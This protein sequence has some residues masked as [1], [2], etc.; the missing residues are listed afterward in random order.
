MVDI[1]G[2]KTPVV[3]GSAQ[4]FTDELPETKKSLIVDA[5]FNKNPITKT[6][7]NGQ[8]KGAYQSKIGYLFDLFASNP[9][10]YAQAKNVLSENAIIEEW[11]RLNIVN[12]VEAD[13]TMLDILV[14]SD[15]AQ[16]AM[17]TL[18]DDYA[19]DPL[20]ETISYALLDSTQSLAEQYRNTYKAQ[21]E[22]YL[23]AVQSALPK[24]ITTREFLELDGKTTIEVIEKKVASELK[25]TYA[26]TNTYS[27][28]LTDFISQ[29][30][31]ATANITQ[32][33]TETIDSRIDGYHQTTI[34]TW[35]EYPD[36]SQSAVITD[37]QDLVLVAESDTFEYS[38]DKDHAFTFDVTNTGDTRVGFIAI[39]N[40]ALDYRHFALADLP[41]DAPIEQY[42]YAMVLVLLKV[43][44]NAQKVLLDFF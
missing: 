33:L 29:S 23:E 2:T 41:S 14:S 10:G 32:T 7:V 20:N 25:L 30:G 16:Y 8:I 38:I 18:L 43:Q 1:L 17:Q 9:L 34:K 13:V 22:A 27:N 35:T 15:G 44:V 19:Y 37:V 42:D 3:Y 11:Y 12:D 36:G 26:Y 21:Q 28:Q 6:I 4:P 5:I 24:S 31:T 40:N 39:V